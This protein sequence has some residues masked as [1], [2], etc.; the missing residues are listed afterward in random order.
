M[1]YS[2]LSTAVPT[3]PASQTKGIGMTAS[4][5]DA[6]RLAL[7]LND[8]LSGL[9]GRTSEVETSE[10]NVGMPVFTVGT[11]RLVVDF[12]LGDHGTLF[13]SS[14][15]GRIEDLTIKLGSGL[16]IDRPAELQIKAFYADHLAGTPTHIRAAVRG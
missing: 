9:R 10:D 14:S 7:A 4:P 1:A 6:A 8:L 13:L 11:F 5:Q 15:T 16:T 3:G 12:N 2:T